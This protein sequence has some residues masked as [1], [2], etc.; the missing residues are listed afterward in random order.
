MRTRLY[1]IVIAAEFEDEQD[2][3]VIADIVMRSLQHAEVPR[4]RAQV[5]ALPIPEEQ[6]RLPREVLD[7]LN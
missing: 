6:V 4:G 1:K 2:E 3:G 5:V 7:R